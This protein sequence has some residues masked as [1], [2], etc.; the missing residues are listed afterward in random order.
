MPHRG[1]LPDGWVDYIAEVRPH[2]D[3]FRPV[4]AVKAG[5]PALGD[6]THGALVERAAVR[7]RDLGIPAGGRVLIDVTVYPD[8]V[9]WLLAPWTAGASI[10]LCKD[11]DD[12]TLKRRAETE[13]AGLSLA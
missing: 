12:A 11:V 7:A 2:G 9:D 6:E 1:T 4:S 8:P 5:D 3:Q 13:R 10:V